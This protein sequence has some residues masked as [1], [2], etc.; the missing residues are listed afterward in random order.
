MLLLNFRNEEKVDEVNLCSSSNEDIPGQIKK[1]SELREQGI[2]TEEEF[3]NKKTELLA[4][5]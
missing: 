5:I 3:N 1:L 2:L 4:R